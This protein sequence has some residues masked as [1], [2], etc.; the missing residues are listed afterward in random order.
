MIVVVDYGV[1]NLGSIVNMFRRAGA[2]ATTGSTPSDLDAADRLVL[3]GV[4]AFDA[5]AT[6]LE[7]S[8]MVPALRQAALDDAKPLLGIC[9]G[10]QLLGRESEEGEQPGLGWID[11]RTRRFGTDVTAAGLKIPH[12]GWSD[13]C[14]TGDNPLLP[15]EIDARPPRYYFLHSYFVECA[16]PADVLATAD[17]GSTFACAIAHENLFAVQFHPEKSHRFGLELF[18]RFAAL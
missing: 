3:P 16:D 15:K 4:G 17:H 9:V 10:M 12:M 18:R 1:G 2:D 11:A 7:Q 6:A 14:V 5:C 13:I 8:G